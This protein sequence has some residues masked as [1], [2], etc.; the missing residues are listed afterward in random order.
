[1]GKITWGWSFHLQHFV[2]G[3]EV[4]GYFDGIV[5]TPSDEKSKV[6]ATALGMVAPSIEEYLKPHFKPK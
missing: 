2:E 5:T 6:S 4:F 1:M 3:Q